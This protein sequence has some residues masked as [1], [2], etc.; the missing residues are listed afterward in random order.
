MR[1][2]L[3]AV[4]LGFLIAACGASSTSNDAADAGGGVPDDAAVQADGAAL[5]AVASGDG[6]GT[7]DGG[8]GGGGGGLGTVGNVTVVAC[9]PQAPAGATCKSITVTGCP[10]IE[11][12]SIDAT[13]TVS[14]G[15]G[16]STGT[17]VHFSG[18]GGDGVENNGAPA[19]NAAGLLQVFVSWKTDWEQTKAS[20]IKVAACRPSTVLKWVFAEPALH[21]SSRAKGFCAQGFS[22]GSAQV[23]YAI[24]HYG[25][26]DYLDYV[27]ELSGPPFAR[28]DLGCNGDAPATATVCGVTDTMVLP[29]KLD[30]WENNPATA[31][32]GAKN[33]PAGD[34]TR[35]MNDSI[36]VGGT[37]AYPKTDVEFFD[38]TNQATAVTAM[39][40]IYEQL[41]AQ[42]E[43]AGGLVGYH[44][45]GAADGCQGEG[46]GP[47]GT[48]QASDALIAGCKPRH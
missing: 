1:G 14:P 27:N 38:C 9:G 26:A 45:V 47:T 33:L 23:G 19:Y 12:E 4:G 28:I 24:A 35:W 2:C 8:G 34:V 48:Q 21:A 7:S 18:G 20:G 3:V 22:G 37:Y 31:K 40:Q 30:N 6:A 46:L 32:C 17:V 43:G 13:I 36:A 44:C 41:I 42:T 16:A 5:D 10:G 11:T 39:A 25:L 15:A 29:P